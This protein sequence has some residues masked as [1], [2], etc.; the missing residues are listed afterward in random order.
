MLNHLGS[1]KLKAF[2]R[3]AQV[4]KCLIYQQ[5]KHPSLFQPVERSQNPLFGHG[6]LIT[7]LNQQPP[8]PRQANREMI[9]TLPSPHHIIV[10]AKKSGRATC[11]IVTLP[12]SHSHVSQ[13]YYTD[14]WR[15]VIIVVKWQRKTSSAKLLSKQGW[16]IKLISILNICAIQFLKRFS[17]LHPHSSSSPPSHRNRIVPCR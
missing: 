11:W 2:L 15:R 7:F 17:Q 3:K 5:S 1:C 9:V 13:C 10:S 4:M 14:C 8:R 12:I 6:K 16:L